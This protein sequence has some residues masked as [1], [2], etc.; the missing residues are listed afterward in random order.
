MNYLRHL[1]T[2][3]GL[4]TLFFA[5]AQLPGGTV[6]EM[7]TLHLQQHILAASAGVYNLRSNGSVQDVGR[8]AGC[9]LSPRR[10]PAGKRLSFYSLSFGWNEAGAETGNTVWEIRFSADGEKWASWQPVVPEAHAAGEP[11]RYNFVSELLFVPPTQQWYQMRMRSNL[12]GKGVLPN[13]LF[14]NCLAPSESVQQPPARTSQTTNAQPALRTNCSCAQPSFI[15]RSGWGCPQPLWN[16]TPTTP[17]HLIV[18]HSAGANTSTN[19]DGVVLAIWNQHVNTNGWSDVGY[20]W[21]IAPNGQLYEG[22]QNSSTQDVTGAHFCGFNGRTMG[23]CMLGTYTA[24]NITPEARQTLI[25]TLAWKACQLNIDL[26]GTS[27]HINSGLLLN[28][29][30][31]HR[32]GCATECPGTTL[33]ADLTAIQF[34]AKA[35]QTNGCVVTPVSNLEEVEQLRIIPNPTQ[36]DALLHLRLRGSHE[37]H[38]RIFTNAGQLL[39]QSAPRQLSGNQTLPLLAL[40]DRPAGVYLVQVWV[41]NRATL[42][43]VVKE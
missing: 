23:V 43:Q 38:Y 4:L 33:F 37:V 22:R 39:H 9:T 34:A 14:I 3:I 20:N 19:W 11:L 28:H 7:E 18:H 32:Q 15:S 24:A 36:G 16:P 6:H 41:N 21:L 17:T 8:E 40:Q 1:F 5:H 10:L 27:V 26:T 35:F 12:L 2:T 29:V 30:S 13:L 42:L 31:G 25:H